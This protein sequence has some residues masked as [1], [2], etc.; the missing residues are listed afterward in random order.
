MGDDLNLP[1]VHAIVKIRYGPSHL[2]LHRL[3][4]HGAGGDAHAKFVV[5]KAGL[6]KGDKDFGQIVARLVKKA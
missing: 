4:V 1:F 3:R 2:L 5:P 6:E